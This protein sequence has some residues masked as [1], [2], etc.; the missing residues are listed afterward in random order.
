M[1]FDNG[2]ETAKSAEKTPANLSKKAAYGLLAA[3]VI[4]WG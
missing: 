4:V 1:K 2:T 3:L